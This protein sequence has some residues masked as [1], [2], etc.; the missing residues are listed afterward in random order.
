MFYIAFSVKEALE[1]YVCKTSSM[2]Q[3]IPLYSVK[4]CFSPISYTFSYYN[5]HKNHDVPSKYARPPNY[6]Y[7][8]YIA[9]CK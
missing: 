3:Y 4:F 6:L 2:I 7:V 5:I 8:R 9:F 1:P